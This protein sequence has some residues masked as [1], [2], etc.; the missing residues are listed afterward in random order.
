M[1]KTFFNPPIFGITVL[2]GSH[3]FDPKGSTSGYVIWINCRGIM[4]DPPI[5]ATSDLKK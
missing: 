2:G 5:F 1:S 4:V 3:G